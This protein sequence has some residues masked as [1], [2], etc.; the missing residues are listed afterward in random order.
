[1]KKIILLLFMSLVVFSIKAQ[2]ANFRA[3]GNYY[4]AKEQ[5]QSHNYNAALDYIY[6]A[7]KTLGGT[8]IQLQYIHVMAAYHAKKY[9]EAKDELET[10]F[11]IQAS[12][13]KPVSFDKYV[14]HLTDDEV[15]EITKIIDKVDESFAAG[16][17]KAEAEK[18]KKEKV[19]KIEKLLAQMNML[20]VE[21]SGVS[22]GYDFELKGGHEKN[23][24]MYYY[25][26]PFSYSS[27][28]GEYSFRIKEIEEKSI[29][30]FKAKDMW[31]NRDAK[32]EIIKIE[33]GFNFSNYLSYKEEKG[34]ENE[35][36]TIIRLI[37]LFSTNHSSTLKLNGETIANY[38]N[39]NKL[40]IY[41]DK[42][43]VHT[44]G[45]II[46]LVKELKQLEGK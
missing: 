9:A 10:F 18:R 1:M 30:Y 27:T 28:N 22:Y 36:A 24:I 41:I 23:T 2:T 12:E 17:A 33:S 31:M 5:Y 43:K 42:N 44:I 39:F 11:K 29:K 35:A 25:S 13:I 15:K 3:Q 38:D 34:S 6:K 37:L 26:S 14:D 16:E 45:E 19:A 4:S 8:N 40:I 20:I 46:N 7:K 21:S 32:K